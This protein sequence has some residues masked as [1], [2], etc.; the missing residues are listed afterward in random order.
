MIAVLITLAIF[1]TITF[2]LVEKSARKIREAEETSEFNF[3]KQVA[4]YHSDK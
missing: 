3:R 2:M 4:K 1:F